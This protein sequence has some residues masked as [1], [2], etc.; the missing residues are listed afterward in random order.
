[1]GDTIPIT[2]VCDLI[3]PEMVSALKVTM[4]KYI[5]ASLSSGTLKS[6]AKLYSSRTPKCKE[7]SS[8]IKRSRKVAESWLNDNRMQDES[9]KEIFD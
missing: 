9:C 2:P 8:L 1:V 5:D 7:W 6:Y 3:I 4:W